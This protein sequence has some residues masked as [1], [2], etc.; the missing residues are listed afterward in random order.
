MVRVRVAFYLVCCLVHGWYSIT[1]ILCTL[2]HSCSLQG[3]EV[4]ELELSIDKLVDATLATNSTQDFQIDLSV[5]LDS[6]DME[7]I[8]PLLR[9]SHRLAT[10]FMTTISTQ[11]NTTTTPPHPIIQQIYAICHINEKKT[12]RLYDLFVFPKRVILRGRTIVD[13]PYV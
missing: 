12:P 13:Y 10:N 6:I 1:G 2:L 9:T 11:S 5:D 3:E 4:I 7:D 8:A